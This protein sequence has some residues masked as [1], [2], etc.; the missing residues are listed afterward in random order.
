VD[1]SQADQ[2]LSIGGVADGLVQS[3]FENLN[4]A[5]IGSFVT[6]TGSAGDNVI[7]GSNGNDTLMG[8][9]GNDTLIGGLGNDELEGDDGT[10]TLIGGLGNDTFA[11]G[12][13]D[14]QDLIQD[15]GG[16]ADKI[17]FDIGIDPLDVVIS[18][19]ANYLRLAIHGTAD[20]VTIQNWYTSSANRIETIQ[21]GNSQ[22]L[23]SSQV[24]QLIQAMA[25]F[26]AQNGGI[27]WDQAIDQNPQG[28][29]A[30][31]AASWQ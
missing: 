4:A 19:Q 7:I 28:V 15:N 27:T 10:D 9:A 1:L 13:G 26:T 12:L 11:F 22:V 2:V 30:V 24:D 18:R 23:L 31:L 14:G 6:A 21:A 25:T 29:Q 3:N 8:G 5:G 20:E 17:G 16:T